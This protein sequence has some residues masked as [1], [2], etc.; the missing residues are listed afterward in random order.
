MVG[1]VT[2]RVAGARPTAASASVATT[3]TSASAAG[4][5][6]AD[7]LDPGLRHLPFRARA[8][9][10]HPQHLPGVAE[11]ERPGVA[12]EPGAGDAGHLRRGVRAQAHHALAHRVHQPEGLFRDRD[13]GAGEQRFLELQQGRLDPLVTVRREG[14]HDGLDEQRLALRLRRQEVRQPR[15]QQGG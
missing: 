8:G 14:R 3:A 15:R 2:S 7:Q 11:P 12:G 6:R 4:R 1:S 9:C 10:P 5:V 13:A